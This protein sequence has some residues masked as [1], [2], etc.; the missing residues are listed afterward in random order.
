MQLKFGNEGCRK[1][2]D[3]MNANRLTGFQ[4]DN[5]SANLITP[6][7]IAKAII[8]TDFEIGGMQSANIDICNAHTARIH[9][10]ST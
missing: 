9:T 3:N 6:V 7:Q 8:V 1:F 4:S 10:R 2:S 5:R